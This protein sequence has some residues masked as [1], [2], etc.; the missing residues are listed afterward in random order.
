MAI[1]PPFTHRAQPSPQDNQVFLATDYHFGRFPYSVVYEEHTKSGPQ[2]YAVAHKHGK[3]VFWP[4]QLIKF[5]DIDASS[6]AQNGS[7]NFLR[8]CA[9]RVGL[10]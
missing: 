5:S 6:A 3:P 4:Q 10:R 8:R 9:H 1:C 2:I 7:N